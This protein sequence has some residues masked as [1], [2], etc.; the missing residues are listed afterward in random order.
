MAT[1]DNIRQ[2]RKAKNIKMSELKEKLGISV[3]ALSQYELNK[4]EPNLEMLHKI[5]EALEVPIS[6]FL[7]ET[8]LA[9]LQVKVTTLKEVLFDLFKQSREL[10]D[11]LESLNEKLK[12]NPNDENS[13]IDIEQV[14]HDLRSTHYLI[15][16]YEHKLQDLLSEMLDAE[17]KAA[18]YDEFGDIFIDEKD[19]KEGKA[20][21]EEIDNSNRETLLNKFD[22]LNHRGKH[23]A[24]KRV[25]ELGKIEEYRIKDE[26]L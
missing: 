11:S 4:R 5:A 18:T 15:A 26:N 22:K 21:L 25:D 10:T 14:K 23:E 6:E 2:I 19:K 17:S 24:I 9:K 7:E 20:L 12:N 16:K 3:Q 1:G 8:P 13:I